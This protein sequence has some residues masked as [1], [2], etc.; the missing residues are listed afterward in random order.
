MSTP[1]KIAITGLIGSGKTSVLNYLREKGYSVFSADEYVDNLY[2]NNKEL[3]HQIQSFTTSDILTNKTIDKEKLRKVFF[4]DKAL[5]E[6]TEAVVH[7][8]VY[9]AIFNDK[10]EATFYEVPL[11][12]ETN[13]QQSFDEVILVV[14]SKENQIKRLQEHRKMTL[15]AIKERL[16]AQMSLQSK[17]SQSDVLLINDSDLPHLYYQ[18]DRYLERRGL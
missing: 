9:E 5:K 14:T 12:F 18:I 15:E 11:L 13:K 7:Q 3:A 10:I 1:K 16:M 6:K 17:M 4:T 2:Q 8:M